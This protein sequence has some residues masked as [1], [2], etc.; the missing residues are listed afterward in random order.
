[1]QEVVLDI[2]SI[3]SEKQTPAIFGVYMSLDNSM[4]L[5]A[6][7]SPENAPSRCIKLVNRLNIDT[8]KDIVAMM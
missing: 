2:T 8:Y 7:S 6:Q 3:D 5:D 1:M 4:K